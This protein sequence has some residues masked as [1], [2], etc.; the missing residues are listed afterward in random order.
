MYYNT[1]L[2]L[3][4]TARLHAIALLAP[5]VRSQRLFAFAGPLNMTDIISTLRELRPDH[6]F[7]DPNPNEGQDLTDVAPAAKAEKLLE[8]FFGQKGWIPYRQSLADEFVTFRVAIK[9][10]RTSTNRHFTLPVWLD[11][12]LYSQKVYSTM[13][14]TISSQNLNER[15][16]F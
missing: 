12:H 16:N 13:V 10:G 15:S 4:I 5:N 3:P 9:R 14:L 1:T 7:D 8:V 11:A 2:M 6:H